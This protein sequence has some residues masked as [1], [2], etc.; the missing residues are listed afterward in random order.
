MA[1]K[2]R[3]KN[4]SDAAHDPKPTQMRNDWGKG[5]LHCAGPA[6]NALYKRLCMV[7]KVTTTL[8]NLEARTAT[9]SSGL[10]RALARLAR[11]GTLYAAET[12]LERG[13]PLAQPSGSCRRQGG[14][15]HAMLFLDSLG[16][17]IVSIAPSGRMLSQ[18]S[19]LA[20]T[21]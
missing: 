19:R 1:Q 16:A 5:S 12:V 21:L 13:S 3:Q 7:T 18:H 11:R 17:Q 9:C 4:K 2:E 6:A 10:V 8:D 15:A 20:S 14:A